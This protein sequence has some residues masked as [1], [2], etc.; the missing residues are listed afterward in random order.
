MQVTKSSWLGHR[1]DYLTYSTKPQ[2]LDHGNRAASAPAP[3]THRFVESDVSRRTSPLTCRGGI[4]P[5]SGRFTPDQSVTGGA[6][7]PE[8]A[9]QSQI[10]EKVVAQEQGNPDIG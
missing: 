3:G 2:R 5:E 6:E 4:I 7:G 8:D 10:V 9:R 1:G